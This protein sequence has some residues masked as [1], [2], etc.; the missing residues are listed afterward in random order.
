MKT[1]QSIRSLFAREVDYFS[2]KK[3]EIPVK[4]RDNKQASEVFQ[5]T[6]HTV[7][8]GLI[9]PSGNLKPKLARKDHVQN[10]VAKRYGGD[11]VFS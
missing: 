1:K 8:V 7:Q 6:T 11:F 4:S 9:R 3:R 2:A 10:V 5:I